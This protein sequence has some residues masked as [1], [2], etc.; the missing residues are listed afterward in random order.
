MY[1]KRL[2]LTN[3][4]P[5][6]KL[7]L[8]FTRGLVGIFGPNGAGKSHVVEAIPAA[9]TNDFGRFPG[10]KL[11]NINTLAGPKDESS[12]YVEAEHNGHE[13]TLYR[14]LRAPRGTPANSLVIGND[15]PITNANEIAYALETTLGL[16]IDVMM[17]Y[18]FIPQWAMFAFLTDRSG[19]RAEAY[20]TLCGTERAADICTA[21]DK[22]IK[23]EPDL[24]NEIVDTS[25][26]W[27]TKVVQLRTAS[28]TAVKAYDAAVALELRLDVLTSYQGQIEDWNNRQSLLNQH[29][30]ESPKIATMVTAVDTAKVFLVDA[31]KRLT[32]ARTAL[33]AIQATADQARIDLKDIQA[34][35]A[36]QAARDRLQQQLSA[37]RT[38]LDRIVI[39][40]R[41]ARDGEFEELQQERAIKAA[42]IATDNA[43]LR[44][45]VCPTCKRPTTSD[46]LV[47]V[48]QRL[49][50]NEARVNE[51]TPLI[52]EIHRAI[53]SHNKSS[54][55]RR[56]S[57]YQVETI[58]A[59]LNTYA[60]VSTETF[61]E[62]GLKTVIANYDTARIEFDSATKA[63]NA[64]ERDLAIKNAALTDQRKRVQDI[65]DLGRA[66][67]VTREEFDI[68]SAA[69]A[70]HMKTLAQAGLL[71][72]RLDDTLKELEGAE[73][74]L[75]AIV[76]RIE[77]GRKARRF[78][79]DLRTIR[80]EI[81]HRQMLPRAVAQANLK[82]LESGINR[83][84]GQF[85]DP[86]WVS[87][88]DDLSFDV[89]FPGKP[90][91]NAERLSGGQK[92]MFALC[93]HQAVQ[94]LF[95]ADIGMMTLDEPT[96]GVDASNRI[97]MAEALKGL[98]SSVRGSK[99]VIVITHADELAPCFDQI[100]QLG[101][102]H[103]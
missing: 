52:A 59:Q 17:R 42:E 62:A 5:H 88:A 21:I 7:D 69:V 90:A 40:P 95:G 102:V 25:D 99:Q 74:Q 79:T 70:D 103:D 31:D 47:S 53:Q 29:K 32:T 55:Q 54:E 82:D 23:E 91:Q 77:R 1:A 58:E 46:D 14:A 24:F 92:M 12:L 2:I 11:D 10:V 27:R 78:G 94:S 101:D 41:H 68:A 49:K 97:G 71:K 38:A 65:A 45:S 50:V 96:A 39:T 15:K 33:N 83:T 84:L 28:E 57:E 80:D 76:A 89:H 81:M 8:T 19:K 43:T 34:V 6:R 67:S 56:Q 37:A 26:D 72:S 22:M 4:G 48:T 3:F 20:Q 87:A 18:V 35:K 85:G 66:I 9:I 86:F 61:D 100:I 64:A 44:S 36:R 30:I 93:F 73:N 63:Y 98:A 13:F 60:D 51:I 16:N 75:N